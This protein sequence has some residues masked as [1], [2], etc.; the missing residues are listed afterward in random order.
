MITPPNQLLAKSKRNGGTTLRDHTQHVMQAIEHISKALG[1]PDATLPIQ[2]AALHDLGKAHPK[3]QLQLQEADGLKPWKS[4][5]EK[6]KWSFVHRHELSSLLLLPCFHREHWDTLIEMIVSHHKSLKEDASQ[7]G[8]MDIIANDGRDTSFNNH[9][10]QGEYWLPLAFEILRSLGFP[11]KDIEQASARQAWEYVV[12]F[13][14][15]RLQHK[16]WSKWR[17]LLMA[18]DHFASAM[19]DRTATELISRFCI[20][21]TSVFNPVEP[22]G[23]LF[24]LS[25]I[26]VND[27]RI[28]TLLVAPTGAG[29]T[30]FLMRRCCGKRIFYTLPFQASINAMWVRFRN[31]MPGTAIHLQ[32]AAAPLVLKQENRDD[33]EE[34]YP[35]H[36]L[37]GSA[38]KVLT[39]HQLAAIVFGL[40]GFEAVMLDLQ[41]TAVV[42]DE[43]HTYSDVSRSMVL[44]IVKILLKL[45]CSIHIGTA[46]MPTAL[47]QEL[48]DLLGGDEKTY[49][50]TLPYHQLELYNRH[51]VYKLA[52]WDEANDI[53]AQATPANE[54]LLIVCNTVKKAQDIFNRLQEQYGHYKHLLIHSRFLRKDRAEKEQLLREEFEKETNACW[55]VATQVV[56]VSLD[57]SFDRMITD[58]APLDALIQRFGRINRRRTKEGLGKQKPVYIVAPEGDQRPYDREIVEKTFS[59]LPD[60]G[61]TL[62]EDKLQAL[63]DAVYPEKPALMDIAAHLVWQNG[64]FRLPPLCNHHSS[65]LQKT[66]EIN[67]ATCILECDRAA[68]EKGTWDIRAG[69]EIPVSRNAIIRTANSRYIQLEIGSWPFVVPQ[70]ENEHQEKGLLLHEHD[71]FL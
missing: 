37:V 29:K 6:R 32:H 34:E 69:L 9:F 43:I 60:Q 50:V 5:Y 53:I 7:R 15:G 22:G 54:K 1:W 39:P 10:K 49:Q 66:L 20:P 12:D 57:I 65:V 63:L 8:L 26:S 52:S 64:T 30:E 58:C 21:D 19:G 13:C 67:S 48:L 23:K 31:K 59:V 33:F 27:S 70:P 41:G 56:E 2:A 28:H 4:L 61:A 62:Q 71:S 16:D 68:Y 45:N 18:S 38:V 14:K 36:G 17:G 55:V 42:L 51:N 40:P 44:E 25:D 11:A 47:Y 35:L 24:P 3:F 46:T